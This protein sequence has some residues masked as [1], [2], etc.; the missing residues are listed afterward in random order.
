MN[1]ARGNGKKVENWV[2][3]VRHPSKNGMELEEKKEKRQRFGA[4]PLGRGLG[5]ILIGQLGLISQI[6]QIG[7]VCEAIQLF[8]R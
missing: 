7:Q 5:I 3:K 2:K 8:D 4:L 6:G 1:Y